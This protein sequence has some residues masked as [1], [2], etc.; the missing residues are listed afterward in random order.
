[1]THWRTKVRNLMC[2][3]SVAAAVAL[4]TSPIILTKAEAQEITFSDVLA[5]P[6]DLKLNLD[7]ARQEVRSGRLQ[8]AAAALERLLLQRPNWDSVRLFY[9]IV[10]YR[11][12]DLNGAI[13]ELSLLEDRGLSPRQ[14]KDRIR[15]LNLA[16]NKADSIRFSARY[17]LGMRLDSNP[18]RAPE[19]DAAGP[20]TESIDEETDAAFTGTSRFRAEADIPTG[21]GD[22]IYF[23][24]TGFINEFFETDTADLIAGRS[25]VGAV[26]HGPDLVISPY[27]FYGSSFLQHERFRQQYGGGASAD[28]TL[29]SQLTLGVKAQA[30]YENYETTSF[31]GIG[32]LRDGWRKS[33]RVSLKYRPMDTQIFRLSGG[34]ADKEAKF[35]GYSYDQ[36]YVKIQSLTLFGEG[37]FLNV[38]AS[39]THTEYDEPDDILSAT[40]AREDDRFYVRA[41]IGAPLQTIFSSLD[42]ELPSAISDIVA[43]IGVSYT[44]QNSNINSLDH[45]NVSGD[46]LFTKRIAF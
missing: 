19:E 16:N 21:Q 46:I 7:Y 4:A 8:Q 13:R 34:F 35:D 12:D 24:S 11:L 3:T 44:K 2:T 27:A 32:S 26:F 14:E 23:Q 17:T 22:Y 29:T 33:A 15:Y 5:S 36:A 41:A 18:G 25:T 39:Y 43:Q 31:S 38:I 20:V 40:L 45:R 42:V 30:A 1:M 37:R 6:D 28:W 10:L 9:G